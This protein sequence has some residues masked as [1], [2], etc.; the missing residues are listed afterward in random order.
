MTY[1]MNYLQNKLTSRIFGQ[2]AQCQ[3]SWKQRI[4][5][6]NKL[7]KSW[8]DGKMVSVNFSFFRSVKEH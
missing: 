1:I 5:Y 6:V 2:C 7:L 4:Y 3:I 8:F